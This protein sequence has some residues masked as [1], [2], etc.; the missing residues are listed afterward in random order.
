M[1]LEEKF[2]DSRPH[3]RHNTD[4][5]D[6]SERKAL[7]ERLQCKSFDWYLHNVYPDLLVSLTRPSLA[8]SFHELGRSSEQCQAQAAQEK[9]SQD[10]SHASTLHRSTSPLTRADK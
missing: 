1:D 10:S 7:R 9:A 5:G 2:F 6:V 3:L 8:L 4:Y